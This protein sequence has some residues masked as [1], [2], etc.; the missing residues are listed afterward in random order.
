MIIILPLLS[1]VLVVKHTISGTIIN[2]YQTI[3]N[4]FDNRS[5]NASEEMK[6]TNSLKN[7]KHIVS[8]LSM[9]K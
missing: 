6:F 1:M 9:L 5:T 3:L 4:Y 7:T 8:N 2:H